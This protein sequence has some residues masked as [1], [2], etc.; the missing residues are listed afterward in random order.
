MATE[1]SGSG[2]PVRSMALLWRG[3]EGATGR[4][5]LSVDRIVA[6]ATEIA[7]AEGIG[8]LSMRKVADKLG[9]GAMSLYT[10]VPG[11]A[12]L[13]D[14]MLD[15]V[16]GET[17][18]TVVDGGWRPR[19]EHVARENLALAR[20][21][22]WV[23]Q[24]ATSRPVLG[25]NLIAKYD[26]E[27]SALDGIGLADTEIDTLLSAVLAYVNGAGHAV[28]DAE[29][30]AAHTGADRR[31]V[32][33][34]PGAAAGEGVRRRAV[35]GRRPRGPGGRRGVRRR[36]PGVRLRVRPAAAARRHRGVRVGARKPVAP[37]LKVVAMSERVLN[38]FIKDGR[39]VSM[40]AKAA[41]RRIVLEHIV[42]VFE[43]G[44]RISEREVDAALRSF[45]EQDWVSLRRYLIDAGLM[46]RADGWYW[47]TGGY[48]DVG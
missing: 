22:P 14:L 27:L 45:Y 19:L 39:L 11:K 41:K 40:P 48:V 26:F 31:P 24:V 10:Y 20:R 44:V 43:P 9:V 12:E 33:G 3:P 2:D 1:Y 16:L 15:Q 30:A 8:A 5:G 42:T 32:V 25:P 47:R 36:R 46:A 28:V 6:T 7:D 4:A 13:I 38:T 23:L 37:L 21:H 17:D 18:R 34:R 35:P 29:Q